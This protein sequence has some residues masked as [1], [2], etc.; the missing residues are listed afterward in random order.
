MEPGMPP[1]KPS[2]FAVP[3][4]PAF[5]LVELLVVIGIIAVLIAILLPAL[6]RAKQSAQSVQCA[7]NMRQ[8]G[9]AIL[10][11]S[12][13]PGHQGR[14]PN[15]G[16]NLTTSITWNQ[17]LNNEVFKTASPT[18]TFGPI[19]RGYPI[20]RENTLACPSSQIDSKVFTSYRPYMLSFMVAG[21]INFGF[22]AHPPEGDFGYVV[23]DTGGTPAKK[24]PNFAINSAYTYYYLGAKLTR[25]RDSA[26]KIMVVESEG[27]NDTTPFGSTQTDNVLFLGQ[28]LPWTA[29]PSGSGGAFAFRHNNFKIS[30]VLFIDGH[31][32]GV[33]APP[34]SG[35]VGVLGQKYRYNFE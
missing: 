30:N 1:K 5:T 35:A 24:V 11:F 9:Q 28:K 10:M 23:L 14:A 19:P 27:G 29:F 33:Q 21:G 8:I 32:T 4:N 22:P 20:V 15:H 16:G 17:M 12:Q 2:K 25:F 34:K 18:S 7:S 6:A 31:V 26:E 3:S 13:L